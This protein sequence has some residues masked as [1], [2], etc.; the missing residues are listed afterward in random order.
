VTPYSLTVLTHLVQFF[1][2]LVDGSTV[3]R[4][5]IQTLVV[6]TLLLDDLYAGFHDKWN[7]LKQ[8]KIIY[9]I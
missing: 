3:A 8:N 4:H 7:I 1:L 5:S 6:Q 2:E 9:K